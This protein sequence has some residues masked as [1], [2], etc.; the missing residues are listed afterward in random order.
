ML[1]NQFKS[2]VSSVVD[3]INMMDSTSKD[4]FILVHSEFLK[5]SSEHLKSTHTDISKYLKDT[6]V[7]DSVRGGIS[8][9]VTVAHRYSELKV[10]TYLDTLTYDNIKGTITLLNYI[11]KSCPDNLK[12]VKSKLSRVKGKETHEYNNNFRR[13][14]VELKSEYKVVVTEDGEIIALT[15]N[16]VIKTVRDNIAGLSNDEIYELMTI[17]DS[18]IER[19]A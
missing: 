19:V 2:K 4:L 1:S 5:V 6:I 15:G 3:S 13:K 7:S 8:K 17:L 16:Q 9:I 18:Q 14:L 12:S 10:I 11:S